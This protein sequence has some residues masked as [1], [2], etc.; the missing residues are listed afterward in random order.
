MNKQYV[1]NINLGK[2]QFNNSCKI[3]QFIFEKQ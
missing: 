1:N 3:N 2:M